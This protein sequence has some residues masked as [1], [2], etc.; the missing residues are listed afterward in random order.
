MALHMLY[1]EWKILP[2]WDCQSK[3]EFTIHSSSCSQAQPKCLLLRVEFSWDLKSR[4]Y[5]TILALAPYPQ[6]A[7]SRHLCSELLFLDPIT[8]PETGIQLKLRE[9][10]CLLARYADSITIS[11]CPLAREITPAAKERTNRDKWLES[12]ATFSVV[13]WMVR[14]EREHCTLSWPS[15]SWS[16][17]LPWE[18]REPCRS[19]ARWTQPS[20]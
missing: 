9:E 13:F 10:W 5:L 3:N 17:A 2:H 7:S 12:H 20:K 6:S 1:A 18:H 8:Q 16:L 19:T 15:W 14:H 4:T 11:F